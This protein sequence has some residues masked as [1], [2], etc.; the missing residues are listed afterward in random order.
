MLNYDSIRKIHVKLG[1]HR[2][3]HVNSYSIRKKHVALCQ[4]KVIVYLAVM[5]T[6]SKRIEI[7]PRID[8]GKLTEKLCKHRGNT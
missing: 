4:H 6:L 8:I 3:I 7:L 2:K 1:Q 5:P